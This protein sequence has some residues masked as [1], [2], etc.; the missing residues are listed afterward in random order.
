[1]RRVGFAEVEG[2]AGDL[3]LGVASHWFA[4]V[5]VD[6]EAREVAAGDVD[7]DTMACFE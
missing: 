1:M 4:G 2:V 5:W 7:A 3:S 6:V